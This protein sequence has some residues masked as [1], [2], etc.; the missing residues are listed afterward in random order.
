MGVSVEINHF[1]WDSEVS[2]EINH[3]QWDSEGSVE[4]NH[5]QWDSEV[6]FVQQSTWLSTPFTCKL[7][8]FGISFPNCY[9]ELTALSS[10]LSLLQVYNNQNTGFLITS[11][12]NYN[13]SAEWNNQCVAA[14]II[15]VQLCLFIHITTPALPLFHT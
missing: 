12:W 7:K 8:G 13:F 3:F 9:T 1:Q 4:I 14:F 5:F 10:F 2:V 15:P 11:I 6:M